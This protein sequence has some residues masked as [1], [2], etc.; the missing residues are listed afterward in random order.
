MQDITKYSLERVIEHLVLIEDHVANWN[1]GIC[2]PCVLFKHKPALAGYQKECSE[3]CEYPLLW[4]Q[5]DN[6]VKELDAIK[7]TSDKEAGAW[8]KKIRDLRKEFEEKL[9]ES[10]IG[11][12]R[13]KGVIM[14]KEIEQEEGGMSMVGLA[15]LAI[16]GFYLYKKYSTQKVQLESVRLGQIRS[17]RLITEQERRILGTF[18]KRI[19]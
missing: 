13:V 4:N 9:T 14:E 8:K 6:F 7:I 19:Q 15:A 2:E 10:D 17:N 1:E 18:R 11:Q 3:A 5:L 12:R 16:L